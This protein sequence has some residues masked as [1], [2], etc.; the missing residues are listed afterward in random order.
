MGHR[1]DNPSV[2]DVGYNDNTIRTQNIV[3]QMAGSCCNDDET[4][5]KML[6]LCHVVRGEKRA[7]HLERRNCKKRLFL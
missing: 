6:R 4:L 3:R 7:S 2:R 1:K 5:N